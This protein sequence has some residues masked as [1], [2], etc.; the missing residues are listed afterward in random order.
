MSRLVD[1]LPRVCRYS[2]VDMSAPLPVRGKK[3][4]MKYS[5]FA[6]WRLIIFQHFLH[7]VR[8]HFLAPPKRDEAHYDHLKFAR[9]FDDGAIF[10]CGRAGW[11]EA[12]F[13]VS[14]NGFG[15]QF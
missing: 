13:G 10:E 12:W 2:C 11:T 9:T 15:L 6:E 14:S 7:L 3:K 8:L 5:C 4:T 1:C